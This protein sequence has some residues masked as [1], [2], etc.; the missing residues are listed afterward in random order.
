MFQIVRELERKLRERF[1]ILIKKCW[2]ILVK[3]N[4]LSSFSS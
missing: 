3:S 1:T 2:N 4:F